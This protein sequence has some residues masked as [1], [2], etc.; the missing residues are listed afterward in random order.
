M[1]CLLGLG[2]R[3]YFCKHVAAFTICDCL[4][5]KKSKNQTK[6]CGIFGWVVDFDSAATFH[7]GQLYFICL[8]SFC[9]LS[10]RKD[11][12]FYEVV[13]QSCRWLK[14]CQALSG[15]D[16]ISFV[17][18]AICVCLCWSR[19]LSNHKKDRSVCGISVYIKSVQRHVH[20]YTCKIWYCF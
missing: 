14:S 10:G 20:A 15:E 3:A 1:S 19:L 17:G 7:Y 5:A 4:K 6:T 13:L 2:S 9:S 11:F 18:E 16:C 8:N 12:L